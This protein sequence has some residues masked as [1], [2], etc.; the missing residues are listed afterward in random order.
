MQE[1]GDVIARSTEERPEA[2]YTRATRA[3]DTLLRWSWVETEDL[4]TTDV[5]SP[6]TRGR[7]EVDMV[8][9]D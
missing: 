8:Q 9:P 6:R 7:K 5:D 4:D 3:G 2:V 1:G